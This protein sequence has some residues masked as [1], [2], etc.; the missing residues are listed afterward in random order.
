MA[1][2]KSRSKKNLDQF[3]IYVVEDHN[4]A[5]GPIYAEIGSRSIDFSGLTM[6]HFDSHP[7]LGIAVD[8]LADTVFKKSELF[9]SLSIE[10]WI[11]PAV[12]AGHL[13]TLVWVRPSWSDQINLGR[14]EFVVGK[15][16]QNDCLKCNCKESYFLSDNMYSNENNLINKRK[17]ELYVCDY[18]AVL[19]SDEFLANL[20]KGFEVNNRNL[21]LDIDLDF[22]RPKTPLDRCLTRILSMN[23]L[24]QFIIKSSV[25]RRTT[26]ILRKNMKFLSLKSKKK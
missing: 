25:L 2:S 8:L 22:F 24:N 6:I 16:A 20:I 19:D 1:S 10:N 9:E 26:L 13:S 12:Y 7:D 5:L 21:L 15:D 3:N 4:E 17:F 23:Y 14:Y 18:D 11:L